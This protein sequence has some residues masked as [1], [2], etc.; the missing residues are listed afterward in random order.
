MSYSDEA[1]GDAIAGLRAALEPLRRQRDEIDRQE[2][3]RGR[4]DAKI[5]A[6]ERALDELDAIF[7]EARDEL[8]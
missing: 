5:A 3:I 6:I 8:L 2:P 4:L 7:D 1:L